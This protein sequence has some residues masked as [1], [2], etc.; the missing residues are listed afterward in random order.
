MVRM[1][2]YKGTGN[3]SIETIAKAAAFLFISL[4]M[5][6]CERDNGNFCHQLGYDSSGYLPYS[7]IDSFGDDSLKIWLE[8]TDTVLWYK[9]E[10]IFHV[11]QDQKTFDQIVKSNREKLDFNF[12]D[13]TLLI[14][15]VFS[16]SGPVEL[17]E[18]RVLVWCNSFDQTISYQV[19]IVSEHIQ[20]YLK[21]IQFHSIITKVPDEIP[22]TCMIDVQEENPNSI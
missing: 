7:T 9:N 3:I 4:I 10:K 12:D 6:S 11:I 19:I 1:N 18:Q 17:S 16:T 2:I 13:F 5:G 8:V 21:A 20:H 15:Y 22:I 14:G